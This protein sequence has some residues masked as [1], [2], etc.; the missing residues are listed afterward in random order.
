[1]TDRAI[2]AALAELEVPVAETSIPSRAAFSRAAIEGVPLVL[3]D[4]D[5][6][7]AQAFAALAAELDP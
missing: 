2:D 1:V 4:P 5:S 7:G 6:D 3:S